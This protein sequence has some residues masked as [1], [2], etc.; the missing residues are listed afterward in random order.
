MRGVSSAPVCSLSGLCPVSVD[1][2]VVV[3]T[4]VQFIISCQSGP[5]LVSPHLAPCRPRNARPSITPTNTH[6][7]LHKRHDFGYKW[8]SHHWFLDLCI[9]RFYFYICLGCLHVHICQYYQCVMDMVAVPLKTNT[10]SVEILHIRM[11]TKYFART[12]GGFWQ[13]RSFSCC[14]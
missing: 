4:V 10:F 14:V 11:D 6:K 2:L 8:E 13:L 7:C 5:G 12:R 3:L 9:G 1:V